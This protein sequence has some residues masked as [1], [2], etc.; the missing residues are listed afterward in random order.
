MHMSSVPIYGTHKACQSD[1]L[2]S[3]KV[4]SLN[5]GGKTSDRQ[6]MAVERATP[7]EQKHLRILIHCL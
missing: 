2:G 5:H 3:R 4:R 6:E 7:Q 1:V